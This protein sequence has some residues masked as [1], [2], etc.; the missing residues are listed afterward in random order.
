MWESSKLNQAL[1][2]LF[3]FVG[4]CWLG[5]IMFARQPWDDN[6]TKN[7]SEAR[8]QKES[9]PF[10]V[11]RAGEVLDEDGVHLAIATF[12]ASDGTKVTEVHNEFVSPDRA[13]QYFEK[14]LR[15][16][17]GIVNRA[18][19]KD[20]KGQ[21]VGERAEVTFDSERE[22]TIPAVLWT[23]GSHFYQISSTSL[24]RILELEKQLSK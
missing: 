24:Q 1:F 6:Q 2:L 9:P 17:K 15:R 22:K 16:A 4:T 10:R 14:A 7:S 20:K 5:T 3:S 8:K 13:R 23:D 19:K 12:E 11:I 21:I 18:K